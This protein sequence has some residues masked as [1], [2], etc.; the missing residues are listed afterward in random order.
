MIL[1]SKPQ[2]ATFPMPKK[3]RPTAQKGQAKFRGKQKRRKLNTIRRELLLK[4]W[5]SCH[6]KKETERAY[7]YTYY[8]Y[9]KQKQKSGIKEV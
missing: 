4:K 5:R 7:H 9:T 3:S 6:K 1:Y 8:Y 2:K